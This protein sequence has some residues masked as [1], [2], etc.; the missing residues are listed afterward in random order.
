M[1]HQP[2]DLM[3]V[4]VVGVD[5]G[6]RAGD[7]E[8][9]EP[10]HAPVVHKQVVVMDGLVAADGWFHSSSRVGQPCSL[11]RASLAI[12]AVPHIIRSGTC[13]SPSAL[14]KPAENCAR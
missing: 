5:L 9:R 3:P 4:E 14:P 12:V 2:G 10:R 8:M 11:L 1:L 6:Q 7:A 13:Q